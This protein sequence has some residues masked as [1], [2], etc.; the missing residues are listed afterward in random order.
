MSDDFFLVGKNNVPAH[1]YFFSL[2]PER[3]VRSTYCGSTAP[4]T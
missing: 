2:I 3:Q 1:I 4:T